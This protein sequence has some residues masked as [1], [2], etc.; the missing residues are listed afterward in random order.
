MAQLLFIRHGQASFGADN[1]DKL[2]A[3][4]QLQ[5]RAVGRE[6]LG[7]D[8]LP[9]MA[10]SGHLTRQRHT[11]D[12]A[13]REA[14]S[15]IQANALQAFDEYD[16]EGIFSSYLPEVLDDYP[17]IRERIT[18]SDFSALKDPG[19][20]RTLFYP[21]MHKWI[22]GADPGD[23]PIEPWKEFRERVLA[24]VSQISAGLIDGQTATVFTSGGVISV[25]MTHVLRLQA[26][27]SVD[28][29]WR[30]A[31]GSITSFFVTQQGLELHKH[32]HD[33]HLKDSA[34]GLRVTFM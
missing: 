5:A 27:D 34:A 6:L 20:F 16:A 11:A 8:R 28:F 9:S 21:V 7:S 18:P 4:G 17:E 31:N 19:V 13:L 23:T 25:I 26:I 29:N 14:G 33:E 32:N 3:L 12:I 2:S 10:F 24:G 22:S 15:D 1:Y 30:T